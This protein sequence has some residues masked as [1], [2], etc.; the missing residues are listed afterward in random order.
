MRNTTLRAA[1]FALL[2]FFAVSCSDA[3]PTVTA[4]FRDPSGKA[5]GVFQVEIAATNEE[6]AKGLMF[7]KEMAESAGMIFLFPEPRELRFWM[8]NTYIPLDMVFVGADDKVLGVVENAAPLTEDPRFV[9]GESKY[10][11]ELGGGVAKKFGIGKGSILT[12]TGQL[13]RAL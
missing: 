1:F 10:V 2:A 5:L 6:R 8:K 7:R 3:A 11:V 9:S 4:T 12:I 13:P